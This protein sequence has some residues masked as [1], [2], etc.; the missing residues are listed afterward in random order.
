MFINVFISFVFS[1]FFYYLFEQFPTT[2]PPTKNNISLISPSGD[3][4]Y[5]RTPARRNATSLEWSFTW[6]E[7]NGR[8]PRV[9]P[10]CLGPFFVPCNFANTYAKMETCRPPWACLFCLGTKHPVHR[11]VHRH[12]QTKLPN[13][14]IATKSFSIIPGQMIPLWVILGF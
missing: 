8:P 1:I 3:V 5:R 2:P 11:T 7:S 9:P 14:Q 13:C 6:C 4:L 12:D 10:A